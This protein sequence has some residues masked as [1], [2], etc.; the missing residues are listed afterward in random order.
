MAKSTMTEVCAGADVHSHPGSLP[1]VVAQ[2]HVEHVE[3]FLGPML[4]RAGRRVYCVK[5][6]GDFG[7]CILHTALSTHSRRHPRMTAAWRSS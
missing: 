3:I 6:M 2:V 1:R 4:L 5:L 7:G